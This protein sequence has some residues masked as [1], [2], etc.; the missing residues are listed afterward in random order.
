MLRHVKDLHGESKPMFEPNPSKYQQ[1]YNRFDSGLKREP[2][3]ESLTGFDKELARMSQLMKV[4]TDYTN[5]SHVFQTIN[6][7]RSTLAFRE[8]EMQNITS[9]YYLTPIKEMKGVSGYLC[10]TC[11]QLGFGPIRD[12]GFEKTNQARHRCDEQ[13]VKD[14]KVCSNRK[15]DTRS[16]DEFLSSRMSEYLTLR[17]PGRKYIES[18]DVSDVFA[19]L[20]KNFGFDVAKKMFGI[21]DRLPFHSIG[22][23]EEKDWIKRTLR[24]VGKKIAIEDFE[25]KE[26][27][28]MVRSSYAMLEIAAERPRRIIIS[29]TL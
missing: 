7:L 8:S 14:I 11:N 15:P 19:A 10:I 16:W 17:M 13:K 2:R 1:G 22:Q 28:M 20:E 26:L 5:S 12:I 4:S 27:L 21:P 25:I 23:N 3:L 9:N 6:N 24:N 29:V 18:D